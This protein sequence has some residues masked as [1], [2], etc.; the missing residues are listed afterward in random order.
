MTPL[1]LA[2]WAQGAVGGSMIAALP[3]ALLAGLVSFLSLCV[4]PLLPGYLSYATGMSAS[5]INAG[6]TRRGRM[7]LGT[8]LFVLGFASVFVLA[9]VVLGAA[10][11]LLLTYQSAI[12]VIAGVVAIIMGLSF[13]GVL[14]FGRRDLRLGV[15]PVGGI[16]G[17][18]LLGVVFGLGWTPCIGP[19]LAVVLNMAMTE[20]SAGRGA[21]LAFVYAL[22]LGLPFVVAGLAFHRLTNTL[23][24]FRR[25]QLATTRIGGSLMII[26]GVLLLT[27]AWTAIT[28]ALRQ[29]ASRFGT[30]I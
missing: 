27:G 12:T 16:S 30:L 6:Q 7:V 4:V 22:G 19:T 29:W 15:T 3:V 28:S 17:A 18:P 24:F 10:G 8:S 23:A 9:G 13:A 11:S 20:G 1:D 5:Q 2:S 25:H 26:V 14:Q 21:L